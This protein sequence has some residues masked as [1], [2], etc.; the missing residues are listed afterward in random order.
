[1]SDCKTLVRPRPAEDDFLLPAPDFG[2]DP[3][4]DPLDASDFTPD[5]PS[6]PPEPRPP[7]RKKGGTLGKKPLAPGEDPFARPDWSPFSKLPP[8]L[9]RLAGKIMKKMSPADREALSGAAAGTIQGVAGGLERVAK[10]ALEEQI[11]AL[12]K[13]WSIEDYRYF[14]DA[15]FKKGIRRFAPSHSLDFLLNC[16]VHHIPAER[17]T[18]DGKRVKTGAPGK[19]AIAWYGGQKDEWRRPLSIAWLKRCGNAM[20]CVLCAPGVRAKREKE[21][22]AITRAMLEMGYEVL[23][24]TWTAFHDI[25]TDPVDQVG[26]FQEAVREVK[27]G[28]TWG[29]FLER[30]GIVEHHQLK[31]QELT[32]D[33]PWH[34]N[35]IT[36]E[37]VIT[38]ESDKTGVHWHHHY[39]HYIKRAEGLPPLSPGEKDMLEA[40]LQALWVAAQIK[41][42]MKVPN[43]V[44]ALNHG[45]RVD[46]PHLPNWCGNYEEMYGLVRSD[47]QGQREC[48]LRLIDQSAAYIASGASKELAPGLGFKSG[49]RA[50]RIDQFSLIELACTT[51]PELMDRVVRV[52]LAL[53]GRHWIEPSKGLKK[54]VNDWLAKGVDASA[55]A[56]VGADASV[57]ANANVGSGADV[58][59]DDCASVGANVAFSVDDGVDG[60]DAGALASA[61]VVGVYA[62]P[63]DDAPDMV[64]GGAPPGA[65]PV[66]EESD[67]EIVVGEGAPV[68]CTIDPVDWLFVSRWQS[69]F[70]KAVI[71]AVRE[72]VDFS[73]PADRLA[74]DWEAL[75]RCREIISNAARAKI[76]MI[77]KGL[78]PLTELPLPRLDWDGVDWD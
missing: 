72:E 19:P 40:D 38:P 8:Y 69:R 41:V 9:R 5:L 71:E 42:G 27:S 63:M 45:L 20:L 13:S 74:Q 10:I 11:L 43:M 37:V 16:H 2:P 17:T 75:A 21:V 51:N 68:M 47:R 24:S 55:D 1:M 70:L 18:R 62:M 12:F 46:Q 67:E 53:K 65:E 29:P 3:G 48:V 6:L 52:A 56:S 39:V 78:D 26:K 61:P 25:W 31:G 30:W 36:G 15:E 14:I 64:V 4:L 28:D 49:H 73:V 50:S 35:A 77:R 23:F 32:D 76:E 34:I 7:R 44:D 66:F 33:A 58:N 57:D 60:S 22:K 54:L 59:A